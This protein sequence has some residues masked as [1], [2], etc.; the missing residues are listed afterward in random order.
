MTRVRSTRPELLQ[1]I[2]QPKSVERDEKRADVKIAVCC[3]GDT[4][5]T[6]TSRV[7][8]VIRVVVVVV[9]VL[10]KIIVV[11]V[12][13]MMVVVVVVMMMIMVVVMVIAVMA[14]R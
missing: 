2:V 4:R 7:I 9:V 1:L 5:W 11:M 3:G 10:V 6:S 13:V 14:V 8:H 12:I